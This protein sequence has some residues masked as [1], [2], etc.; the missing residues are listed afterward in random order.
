MSCKKRVDCVYL[1]NF[2]LNTRFRDR[3]CLFSNQMEGWSFLLGKV[4]TSVCLWSVES[5]K[6]ELLYKDEGNRTSTGYVI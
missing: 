1:Q 4:F 5:R 6:F 3:S 2:T